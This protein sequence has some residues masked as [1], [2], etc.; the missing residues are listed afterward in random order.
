MVGK[1]CDREFDPV[2]GADDCGV[3]H[4]ARARLGLLGPPRRQGHLLQQGQG[5]L[6]HLHVRTRLIAPPLAWLWL[7]L[8]K[9][10]PCWLNENVTWHKIESIRVHST[11]QYTSTYTLVSRVSSYTY[12]AIWF[13]FLFAI[14]L[15]LIW[16]ILF[17]ISYL[18]QTEICGPFPTPDNNYTITKNT[19]INVCLFSHIKLAD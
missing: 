5:R 13:I 2:P 8:A 11:V 14:L 3:L 4:L 16:L 10:L 12:S 15:G 6:L 1:V 7:P 19:T 18:P 17:I 9:A